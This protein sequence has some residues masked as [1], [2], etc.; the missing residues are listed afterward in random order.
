ML[1]IQNKII[2]IAKKILPPFKRWAF[3]LFVVNATSYIFSAPILLWWGMPLSGLSLIGNVV[4][5]PVLAIFIMQCALFMGAS[6]FGISPY[7]LRI[8]LETTTEWWFWALSFGSKRFLYAQ[9]AHPT[10]IVGA[11]IIVFGV[12]WWALHS[13]T[14]AMILKALIS[15]CIAITLIFAIPLK[16]SES[17]LT[18]KSGILTITQPSSGFINIDDT[19]FFK[20]LKT[21]SKGIP[22]NVKRPIIK[23]HGTLRVQKLTT[24]TLS[25][26]TLE[27]IAELIICM[28]VREVNLPSINPPQ[29]ASV[30]RALARIRKLAKEQ[31]VGIKYAKNSHYAPK[32]RTIPLKSSNT[33]ESTSE[34]RSGHKMSKKTNS[35]YAA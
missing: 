2:D 33:F 6:F 29:T 25:T 5:A 30:W 9:I 12:G 20:G 28:D 7:F 24:T 11:I 23:A 1:M 19:G 18:N 10:L 21:P 14:K 26:R 15:G 32:L 8:P 34:V 22:F 27:S 16:D 17:V 3:S 35:E 31:N 13:T 4:F